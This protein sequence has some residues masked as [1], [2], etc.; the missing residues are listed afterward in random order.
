MSKELKL[1]L[2]DNPAGGAQKPQA[3][4]FIVGVKSAMVQ[5]VVRRKYVKKSLHYHKQSLSFALGFF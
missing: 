4:T 5:M 3:P 2:D 1:G